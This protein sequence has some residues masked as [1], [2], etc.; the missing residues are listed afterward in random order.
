MNHLGLTTF[1][2]NPVKKNRYVG[3]FTHTLTLQ[4]GRYHAYRLSINK[5]FVENLSSGNGALR[6][7]RQI[8]LQAIKTLHAQLVLRLAHRKIHN[9]VFH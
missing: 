8:V 2:V 9:Y 5:Q 7:R 4:R 1:L 6:P 3:N